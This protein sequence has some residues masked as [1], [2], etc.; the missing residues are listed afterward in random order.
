MFPFHEGGEDDE[1]DCDGVVEEL[2]D[3]DLRQDAER[4]EIGERTWTGRTA[5]AERSHLFGFV[6]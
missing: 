6:L 2:Q 3:E 5:A 4:R 1:D